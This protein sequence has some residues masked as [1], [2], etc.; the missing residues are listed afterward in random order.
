MGGTKKNFRTYTVALVAGQESS[1]SIDGD[2]YAVIECTDEFTLTLDES[3]RLS[4]QSAGMG[5]TFDSVYSKVTL[6]SAIDQAVTVILGYGTFLDARSSVNATINTTVAPSN[7]YDNAGD[8]TIGAAA[9]LIRA[10]DSNAKEILV[11]VPSGA[12]NSIRIGS[13]AVTAAS[14]LEVEPG[15]TVAV[16]NEGALYGIRDGA[17]DVDISAIKLTRP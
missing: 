10:A 16:S 12:A 3:N 15:M 6:L 9:T 7:T 13:A 14:G 11:H 1:F 4:K 17:T 5:G 8:V 2:M